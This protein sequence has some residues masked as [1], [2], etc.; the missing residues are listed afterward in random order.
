[1]TYKEEQAVPSSLATHS[2]KGSDGQ[3]LDLTLKGLKFH[4]M[5]HGCGGGLPG[6]ANENTGCPVKSEF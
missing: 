4:V 2:K 5:F 6:L 1:M 3:Q